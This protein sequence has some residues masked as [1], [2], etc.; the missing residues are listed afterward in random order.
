MVTAIVAAGIPS[1][2]RAY[3]K[4]VDSANAQV[5][6]S[7][8]VT[9]LREEL[10]MAREADPQTTV[11]EFSFTDRNGY[12]A[13]LKN[14]D[15]QIQVNRP[16]QY[17]E[18]ATDAPLIP[19]RAATDNLVIRFETVSYADGVFTITNLAVTKSGYSQPLAKLDTL[20]IRAVGMK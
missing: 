16:Q 12:P 15:D 13:V 4:V 11:T 7:T 2:Q 20:Q 8:T 3:A 18:A 17:G 5:L 1:A 14:G 19:E 10:G 6:L 9:G